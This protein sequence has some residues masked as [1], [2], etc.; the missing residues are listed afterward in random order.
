MLASLSFEDLHPQR[1]HALFKI[2]PPRVAGAG[3][4]P[5][6]LALGDILA[7]PRLRL[8]QALGQLRRVQLRHDSCAPR[9]PRADVSSFPSFPNDGPNDPGT[10]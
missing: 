9:A 6:E 10:V 5:V 7:D 3:E 2:E 8:S 1:P 4:A